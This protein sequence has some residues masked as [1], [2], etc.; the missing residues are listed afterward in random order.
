MLQILPSIAEFFQ[1]L[2][3][4]NK[5]LWLQI[6]VKLDIFQ[7]EMTLKMIFVFFLSKLLWIFEEISAKK[8]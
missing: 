2:K 5:F 8:L 6:S 7:P 4:F 1:V 3:A